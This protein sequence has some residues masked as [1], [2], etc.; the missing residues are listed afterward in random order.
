MMQTISYGEVMYLYLNAS[1][2]LRWGPDQKMPHLTHTI[3]KVHFSIPHVRGEED[4]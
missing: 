3:G 4:I 2:L 1:R